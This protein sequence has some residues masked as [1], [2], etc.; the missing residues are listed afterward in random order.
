ME[1]A[2][3]PNPPTQEKKS[4]VKKKGFIIGGIVL[5]C[6]VLLILIIAIVAR[7]VIRNVE[8]VHA[9]STAYVLKTAIANYYTEYRKYPVPDGIPESKGFLSDHG[10]MDVLL[11]KDTPRKIVFITGLKAKSMGGGKYRKGFVFTL[12]GGGE[13]WDPWGN[14][15]HIRLDLNLDG[16]VKNPLWDKS[17][18]SAVLPESILIWS[19]GKD[20]IEGTKDD[21]NTW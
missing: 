20:G 19:A 14:Y 17:S 6:G 1:R 4:G 3:H 9:E 16:K 15:Y 21:I 11:G 12:G 10:V 18:G 5:G 8:K 13:L 7:N 2:V